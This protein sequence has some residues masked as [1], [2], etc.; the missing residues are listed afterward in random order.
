MTDSPEKPTANPANAAADAYDIMPSRISDD[1]VEDAVENSNMLQTA[2][3]RYGDGETAD[4]A[5]DATAA[6]S[7]K[8]VTEPHTLSIT[9]DASVTDAVTAARSGL[10]VCDVGADGA[11]CAS[12]PHER[13]TTMPSSIDAAA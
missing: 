12:P 8:K 1:A 9:R 5:S 4:K 7:E 10:S 13:I 2:A 3:R 11:S 6:Q